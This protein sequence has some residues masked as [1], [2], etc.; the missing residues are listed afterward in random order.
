MEHDES[1]KRPR[2]GGTPLRDWSQG[3]QCV[4]CP[5]VMYDR[6]ESGDGKSARCKEC[7]RDNMRKFRAESRKP[8]PGCEKLIDKYMDACGPCRKHLKPQRKRSLCAC[9]RGKMIGRDICG[10]CREKARNKDRMRKRTADILMARGAILRPLPPDRPA[11]PPRPAPREFPVLAA[12]IRVDERPGSFRAYDHGYSGWTY[13][14]M[15]I[16]QT[17]GGLPR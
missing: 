16:R 6:K 2:R 15:M 13:R 7:R 12:D 3:V 11:L 8:C 1:I 5:R 14:P 9:G 17:K 10:H 4:D